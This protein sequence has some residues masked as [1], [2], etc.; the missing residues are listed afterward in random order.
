MYGRLKSNLGFPLVVTGA[1]INGGDGGGNGGVGESFSSI[2][3]NSQIRRKRSISNDNSITSSGRLRPKGSS[4][5]SIFSRQ[6]ISDAVDAF[7][8]HKVLAEVSAS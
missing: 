7:E 1:A 6:D 3:G 8:L 2:H 5:R 4:F